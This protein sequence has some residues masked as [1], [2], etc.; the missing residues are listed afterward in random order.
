M[1]VNVIIILMEDFIVLVSQVIQVRIVKHHRQVIHTI[2]VYSINF[3]PMVVLV[4][5]RTI[6]MDMSVHVHQ[7]IQ[8]LI[9]RQWVM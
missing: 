9:V 1:V 4:R 7:V 6:K 3:V 8:D 5:H 2:R